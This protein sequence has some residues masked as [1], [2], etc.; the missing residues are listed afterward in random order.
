MA[1]LTIVKYGDKVLRRRTALVKSLDS[2][3][4]NLIRDMFETM[5]AGNGIG[6]AA[7]QVNVSLRLAVVNVTPDDKTKGIAV[8]NPRIVKRS[9]RVESEEGCLSLPG[10]GSVKVKRAERITVEAMDKSGL[11]LTI[12]AEGL[13]ARCLEHE[14]DHLEGI[15]LVQRSNLKKRM[16]LIWTIRR[17][18][19]ADLW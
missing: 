16:E 2:Q 3:V 6:L 18:K 15:T 14:I 10:V 5:Y 7:P 19:K 12:Q 17:L 11:P 13:L 9:G 8:I 4:G 1:L